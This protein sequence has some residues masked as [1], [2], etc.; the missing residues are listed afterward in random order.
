MTAKEVATSGGIAVPGST[1]TSRP[2]SIGS[3]LRDIAIV[4]LRYRRL[5][6]R[7]PLLLLVY[8]GQP[9]MF[10]LLF[11][12]VFGN[13]LGG[14]KYREFLIAGIMALGV[15]F[16]GGFSAASIAEDGRSGIMTRFAVLPM[17]RIAPIAGRTLFDVGV[18]L[19]SVAVMA[20]IGLLVGWR[21]T[22]GFFPALGGILLLLL[23]GQAIAWMGCF[24]GM[25]SPTGEV[26]Q[27]L[28]AVVTFPMTFIS[29]A[30]VPAQS[31]P[32]VL[33][34]V[35]AWNPVT[36]LS[37]ALR[38]SFGNPTLLTALN[39]GPPNWAAQHPYVYTAGTSLAIIAV[40]V[41]LVVWRLRTERI[42]G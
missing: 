3:S 39:P 33:R 2:S 19:L 29:S 8:I 32:S 34:P 38:E 25:V 36:T 16:N 23:F 17:S 1:V 13:A 9:L 7:T 6:T 28:I 42:V 24:V 15:A 12:F 41:S 4:A 14:D 26:A 27:S 37:Q 21:I 40:T 18:N 20:S 10:V 35:A 5:A 11:A 22:T 30:L 31:L